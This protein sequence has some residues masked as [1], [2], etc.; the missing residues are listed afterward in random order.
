VDGEVGGGGSGIAVAADGDATITKQTTNTQT[1]QNK[2]KQMKTNENSYATLGYT[3]RCRRA[4][5]YRNIFFARSIIS[6]PVTAADG[7]DVK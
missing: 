7:A 5:L 3:T 4:L 1:K 2:T 6:A